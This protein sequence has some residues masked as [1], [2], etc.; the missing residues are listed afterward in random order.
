MWGERRENRMRW[1]EGLEGIVGQG[2]GEGRVEE[3]TGEG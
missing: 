1:C 2:G 3:G